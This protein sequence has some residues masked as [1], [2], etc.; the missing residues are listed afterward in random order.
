MLSENP[1][2][3]DSLNSEITCPKRWWNHLHVEGMT[4]QDL[5]NLILIAQ[6]GTLSDPTDG[7]GWRY[8]D[9]LSNT[10]LFDSMIMVVFIHVADKTQ[11]YFW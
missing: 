5:D 7:R 11:C 1:S 4:Q 9:F 6:L 8:P 3:L 2:Y 10:D